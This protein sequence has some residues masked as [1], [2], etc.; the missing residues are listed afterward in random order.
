MLYQNKIKELPRLK[1]EN[2]ENIF[3]L[4]QNEDGQYFYNLLQTLHFPDNLPT[5]FFNQ[6]TIEY[7]DTLPFIAYK[8]YN[9]IRLWWVITH[10]NNILNPTS[11]LEPGTILKIPKTEIVSAILTQIALQDD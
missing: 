4:Y 3:K 7:G 6:Y 1:D 2:Y 8:V 5:S 10:A 11:K 9:N